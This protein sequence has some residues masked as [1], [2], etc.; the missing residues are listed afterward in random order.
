M[1]IIDKAVKSDPV[2]RWALPD[3]IFFACGA[4]HILAFAFL[5]KYP[6]SG[7]RPV[8]IKPLDGHMGNHIYVSRSDIAFDYHGYSHLQK[9]LAHTRAKA[10]RWWPGWVAE[11]VELPQEVLISESKSRQYDG[12]WLREP[13]QF[14]HDALP[15]ARHLVARFSAPV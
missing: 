6:S 4:C 2:K 14:L 15:R 5:E 12:L 11:L 1:Y 3:R 7:F 9:L 8:W 10:S 13:K